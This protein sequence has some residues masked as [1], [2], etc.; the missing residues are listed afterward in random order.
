MDNVM[1]QV[2]AALLASAA[3]EGRNGEEEEKANLLKRFVFLSL[4][5]LQ[6]VLT[7]VLRTP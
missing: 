7:I 5:P 2:E 3:R 1:F 4:L 6:L